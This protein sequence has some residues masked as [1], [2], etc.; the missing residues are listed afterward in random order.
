MLPESNT[1]GE[2]QFGGAT[3]VA[4]AAAEG[5]RVKSDSAT[6][7]V[8]NR[9]LVPDTPTSGADPSCG[10]STPRSAA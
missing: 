4:A 5:R 7:P 6:A 2:P 3:V 10:S 9:S 8:V 1:D